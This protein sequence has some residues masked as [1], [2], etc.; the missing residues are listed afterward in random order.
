MLVQGGAGAVGHLATQLAVIGGA[1]VLSTVSTSEKADVAARAGADA[2]IEYPSENVAERVLDLT[3]GR[4]V[5]RIIEVDLAANLETDVRVVKP[6]GRIVSYSSTSNPSPT[7]EYYPLAFKDVRVH[8]L[9]GYLLPPEVRRAA[10]RELNLW[11]SVGQLEV[12]IGARFPLADTAEAHRALEDGAI[13]G[14][15]VIDVTEG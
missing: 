3:D 10:A 8:F 13:I 12:L 1:R 6:N 14:N 4:G 2:T 11:S 5:D 15:I 9:Q 7:V